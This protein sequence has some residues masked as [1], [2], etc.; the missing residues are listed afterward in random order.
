MHIDDR[1]LAPL[2]IPEATFDTARARVGSY[3]NA[4]LTVTERETVLD[5]TI[6]MAAA[7]S[8][9]AGMAEHLSSPSASFSLPAWSRWAKMLTDTKDKK[10][11][12]TVFA[13]GH[14]LL[15]ALL[16]V[17]EGLSPVGGVGGHLRDLFARFL[18]EAAILLDDDRLASEAVAWRS[19]AGEWNLLGEITLPSEVPEFARARDL[20][21]N[22]TLGA[23]N[24][25]AGAAARVVCA[26][27]LWESRAAGF[28]LSDMDW[29]AHLAAMKEQLLAIRAAE[30]AAVARLVILC[31]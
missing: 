30:A 10:G 13:G 28:D 23:I 2:T 4:G 8:G 1:T 11:W 20:T 14:N 22:V 3:K 7:R 31:R 15:G 6:V 25:D 19:V 9:I 21:R 29:P 16:S 26:A 27:E 5:P 12:P 24:G 18:G 17:W